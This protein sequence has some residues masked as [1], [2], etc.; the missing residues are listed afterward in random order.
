MGRSPN[1]AV[2]KA[3]LCGKSSLLQQSSSGTPGQPNTQESASICEIRGFSLR[4]LCPLWLTP[5]FVLI[6]VN[7]WLIPL[8]FPL[9]SS[10]KIGYNI[11]DGPVFGPRADPK[12]PIEDPP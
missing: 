10:P 9:D 2:D 6:R 11:E 7:L 3:G 12:P 5:F 8:L 1:D 4:S